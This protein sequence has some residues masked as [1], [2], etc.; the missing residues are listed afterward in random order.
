MDATIVA[1]KISVK[2]TALAVVTCITILLKIIIMR[3]NQKCKQE[4]NINPL[5]LKLGLIIFKHPIP[6]SEKTQPISITRSNLLKQV[7]EAFEGPVAC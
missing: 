6:T 2:M 3:G 5:N 7:K 1:P 4:D